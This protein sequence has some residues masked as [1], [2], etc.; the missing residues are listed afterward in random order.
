MS[1]ISGVLGLVDGVHTVRN[2]SI[3]E[4]ADVRPFVASNTKVAT[5]HLAGNVDWNGS[6]ECYGALP[7]KLPGEVFTF[8]GS[9][10]GSVGVEGQA[11]VD[12]VEINVDFESADP[13]SH[14]VNFSGAGVLSRGAAVAV[15]DTI[16]DAV[17]P[18]GKVVEIA[19]P[20]SD[21]GWDEIP[22]VKSVTITIESS[23]PDYVDSHTNGYHGRQRGNISANMSI[24]VN[25]DAASTLPDVNQQNRIRVL[26]G[27]GEHNEPCDTPLY[28]DFDAI[29]W[30]EMSDLNVNRE[31]AEITSATLNAAWAAYWSD[32]CVVSEGHILIPDH[33]EGALVEWW[34]NDAE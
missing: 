28:W 9:M 24:D 33:D 26:V 32:D 6:F 22:H 11:I 10:D 14:T 27:A 7:A 31:T 23:N 15:D 8:T 29:I 25:T 16:P 18:I 30:S 13:I 17:S 3:T 2:W 12:S 5:G 4:T 34:P 19:L 20:G 21:T 1:V